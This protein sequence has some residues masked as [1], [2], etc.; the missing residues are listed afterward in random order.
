MKLFKKNRSENS[1]AYGEGSFLGEADSDKTAAGEKDKDRTSVVFFGTGPVAARSLRLLNQNFKIEAVVTKPKPLG[2]K[3]EF[4]VL[5]AAEELRLKTHLVTSKQSLSELVKTRPFNSKLGVLIDFGIILAQDVIDYFP[6]GI[7]NSH[8]SLLPYWRGAD[9]ISFAILAGDKKTGVSLMLID[10]SLD[11]GK[12]LVQKS[13]AV[14]PSET[15]PSLTQKLIELSNDLLVEYLPKYMGGE[16]RP[17]AQPHPNRATY[18]RKLTK[19]DGLIDW[20]KPAEQIER[21]IRA[22]TD[23]PKSTT[24]FGGKDVVV[25]KASLVRR[26]GK[27]GTIAVQDKSLI[28]FA[29]KDALVIEELKPAGKPN[30]TAEAFIAGYKT[31]LLQ[32]D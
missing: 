10:Q 18:S 4:P 15:T 21:E 25:T 17:R 32:Q 19:E 24:S 22:F 20:S 13:L 27:P 14:E 12:I 16:V 23:W 6:F 31:N 28:A 29:G 7:V 30:M 11:T 2:F 9:P 1:Y 5:V 3:G 8:F 26:S